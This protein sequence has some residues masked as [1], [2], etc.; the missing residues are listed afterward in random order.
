EDKTRGELLEELEA[1]RQRIIQLEAIFEMA[2]ESIWLVDM[3]DGSMVDFNKAAHE[4]LGY[5]HEEFGRLRIVDIEAIENAEEVRARTE[6][7]I[8]E[9]SHSF[10]SKHRTKDGEIRDVA[11]NVTHL[12]LGDKDYGLGVLRDI[13]EEK[14]TESE[15][16]MRS[17]LLDHVSD[18]I[19]ATDQV[20]RVAYAN[21]AAHGLRGLTQGEMIGALVG[22]F[23][24]DEHAD[25]V[26][27]RLNEIEERGECTFEVAFPKGD[28]VVAVEVHSR[29][30]EM[31]GKTLVLGAER[32]VT[33][34]KR[35]QK[36]SRTSEAFLDTVIDAYPDALMVI[37]RDFSVALANRVARERCG[38][39]PVSKA[40]SCYEVMHREHAPCNSQDHA[41]PLK[42]VLES[43]STVTVEHTHIGAEGNK[44]AVEITAAPV[45][46]ANGAVVQ[47]IET[48]RDITERERAEEARRQ[49]EAKLTQTLDATTDGI[50]EWDFQTNELFFS[51][52]YY[53]MLGYEPGEFPASFESWHGLI[54]PDDLGPA[55][56][57]AEQYLRTKPDEYENE[58]RMRTKSGKY[59]WIHARGTV[60]ERDGDGETAR[61]IGHHEDVSERKEAEAALRESEERFRQLVE[62]SGDALFL[63]DSHGRWV[64][65]NKQ[66]CETLGYTREE[67][68]KLS[69]SDVEVGWKADALSGLWEALRQGGPTT[70]PGTHRRKDGSTFP[71][72]ARVSP[73]RWKE[74]NLVLVLCRDVT[75][76]KQAEEERRR[77]QEQAEQAQKLKSL[78]VLA[79][80][81]AHDFNNALAGI[82][83]AMAAARLTLQ[84][85]EEAS[86]FLADAEQAAL[87]AK[88]LSQQL[89]TF[90]RGGAPVR[91]STSI[92]GLLQETVSFGLSGS[93]NTFKVATPEGLWPVNIDQGQI[94]QV[95]SNL[96]VNA[97]QA[98][99]DGGIV[100]VS[101]E[102]VHVK[103][104]RTLPLAVG[105]YVRVSV[106]DQGVGISEKHLPRIFDPYF[107]TKHAGSGLGLATSHSIVRKH[108]GHVEVTSRLGEGTTFHVY[109]PVADKEVEQEPV[110]EELTLPAAKRI[111]L[112]D[113]EDVLRRTMCK[114]LRSFGHEVEAARAGS[115][116][117]RLYQEAMECGRPFSLV[118]LDLTIAGGMGGQETL[119]RLREIDPEVCSIVSSGYAEDPILANYEEYGF[120]G[121]IAK[122]FDGQR[123]Q[124]TVQKAT[125]CSP[126]PPIAT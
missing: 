37:N 58:F 98:M 113:D 120:C 53:T 82:V 2:G 9:G 71:I 24:M 33:E 118:I 79:G 119:R 36:A 17:A 99:P 67:L 12:R 49:G 34:R 126:C 41:C 28:Q 102:N 122:P 116:A 117:I 64:H 44:T 69:V 65:V 115:E 40:L 4:V 6:K 111:L 91:E 78:G 45:F 38:C 68:L 108:D 101:A 75:E 39:D 85:G 23:D 15:L 76:R 114:L 8:G 74:R 52:R 88:N 19:T 13:T 106:A 7:I 73:F 103:G 105:R 48:I 92:A 96:V 54:H 5:T 93:Q 62:R 57:V 70:V 43:N 123:L 18:G 60:V 26:Q 112:M 81:I 32:D 55:L 59:R 10:E 21:R 97:D 29:K 84:P 110:S 95:I 125:A 63:H 104:E 42:T 30:V 22:K 16:Q 61:M 77:L 47:V 56:S 27:E 31:K 11:L 50:W 51:D 1:A 80:G 83:C 87:H 66:A 72:E 94:G 20:G 35:A 121:A 46:D 109:L 89:L 100:N 107:T 14:R 3:E 25:L 90:A 124:E 86:G